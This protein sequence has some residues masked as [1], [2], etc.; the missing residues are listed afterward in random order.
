MFLTS[1]FIDQAI[2]RFDRWSVSAMGI[3]RQLLIWHTIIAQGL[4]G[5]C[6]FWP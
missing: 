5:Y 4:S 6:Q 1:P 2:A 3:L